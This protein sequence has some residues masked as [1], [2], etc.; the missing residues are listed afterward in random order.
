MSKIDYKKVWEAC[1]GKKNQAYDY[2]GRLI[3]KS[4][5]NDRSSKYGWN[6]DHIRPISDGGTSKQCNLI[7]SSIITNDEK[8]DA[9]PH[10]KANG[11]KFKALK[12]SK[13]CYGIVDY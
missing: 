13:N 9:F 4:A 11:K 6:V 5:Y 10:W 1:F 8:G 3:Y 2:S 12:I 7:A